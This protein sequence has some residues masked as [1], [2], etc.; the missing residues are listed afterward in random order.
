MHTNCLIISPQGG[1]G[2]RLRAVNSALIIAEKTRRKLLHSWLPIRNAIQGP[3]HVSLL[4]R[5]EFDDFFAPNSTIVAARPDMTIDEVYSE[6]GP[7]DGWFIQQSTGQRFFNVFAQSR[8]KNSAN[9]ILNSNSQSILLETTLRTWPEDAAGISLQVPSGQNRREIYAAYQKIR[10]R[11]EYLEIIHELPEVDI[12]ISIRRGNLLHYCQQARQE[13]KGIAN[14]IQALA[15]RSEK[16][17]IFSDDPKFRQYLYDETKVASGC[18]KIDKLLLRTP[19]HQAAFLNFLYLA[20][21]CK[22]IFGTPGSSFAQEAALYGDKPYDLV[23]SKQDFD[24]KTD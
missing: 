7:G 3:E 6:W 24:S 15:K 20:L 13:A 14:W 22:F 19:P 17:I 4:Q 8:S 2:N 11:Q 18:S 1:L 5:C 16:L 21:K 23:L 12:G 9:A 10:P